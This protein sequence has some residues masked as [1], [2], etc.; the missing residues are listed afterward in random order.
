MSFAHPRKYVADTVSP[1]WREYFAALADPEAEPARP[2]PADHAGWAALHADFGN[3]R[4]EMCDRAVERTGVKLTPMKLGGVP[5]LE[6]VPK[7]WTDDG[8]VLVYCHGGAYTFFTAR[9]TLT[10]SATAAAATGM[11]VLSIDYTNPPKARWP[12]V[13]DEVVT[14]FDTLDRQ[15]YESRRIAAFGDSAGAALVAGSMLKLR[16]AGRPLPAA[17]VLWSPWADITE[18]GETYHTLKHAEPA[19]TYDR[20]LGP[21]AATYADPADQKHPYVSPVYGDFSGGF[22]PTLIQGGTREIFL[23]NFVRLYRAMDA[24]G[25]HAVLDLYEGMPHV[26]QNKLPETTE[27][28]AALAVMDRFLKRHLGK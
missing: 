24:A 12:E 1:E 6:I 13:T 4:K 9:S 25:C 17:L 14:V 15:G 8:K 28:A 23:S 22:A 18:T 11:R 3:Q 20:L 5:V 19:Y 10:S 16:D 27:A 7:D 26:F 2:A 21:A